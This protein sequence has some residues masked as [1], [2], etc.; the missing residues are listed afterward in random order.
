MT[1]Q[2]LE[3]FVSL[4]KSRNYT[5]VAENMHMSQPTVSYHIKKLEE[6][7]GFSLFVRDTRSVELTSAG[8]ALFEDCQNILDR[9][10][11]AVS[12]ARNTAQQFHSTLSV[13]CISS[14]MPRL[15]KT[16]ELFHEERPDVYLS[17]FES[18]PFDTLTKIAGRE[19]S[20]GISSHVKQIA[21]SRQFRFH[22]LLE[23]SFICAVPVGSRLAGR[24]MIRIADLDGE[25]LILL[26][27]EN[28]P[29]ELRRLQET[30]QS[31]IPNSVT[32][33]SGAASLSASMIQAKIGSAVMPDFACPNKSGIVRIPV[34]W[35]ET[36][37]I[38]LYRDSRYDSLEIRQFMKCADK[39]FKEEGNLAG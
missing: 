38:G 2:Q 6:E 17:I 36:I 26:K 28:A 11:R 25:N 15:E 8:L 35:P 27:N 30:I 33:Y 23:G 37:Q 5:S 21:H 1:K 32:Y 20:L 13:G 4:G 29:P 14:M 7:L 16:L 10:N 34:E 9:L 31:E 19:F 12:R 39:A 3:I 18:D 22:P 24:K